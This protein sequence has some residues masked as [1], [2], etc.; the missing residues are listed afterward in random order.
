MNFKFVISD[1][2]RSWQTEKPQSECP[3][4]GKKIGDTFS[5][6]FLGLDGYE[7]LITGGSDK[8]GFPMRKDIEGTVRKSIVITR[9]IGFKGKKGER[10]R[11]NLRGNIIAQDIAQIN[12]K[13]IKVGS[14]PLEELLSKKKEE[15]K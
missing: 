12:C 11:K 1:K 9:G 7:L 8:D 10:I 14:M 4:L 13:V 6:G 2:N 5:A 15:G 3:I